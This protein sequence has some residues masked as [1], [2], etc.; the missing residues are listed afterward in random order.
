MNRNISSLK[1]G[2]KKTCISFFLLVLYFGALYLY[3]QGG[4]SVALES[5]LRFRYFTLIYAKLF[6]L[7]G[8]E[9]V[10]LALRY[11]ADELAFITHLEGGAASADE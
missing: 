7:H 10:I 5:I 9:S 1:K 2:K 11:L 8:A 6:R 3:I 4:L